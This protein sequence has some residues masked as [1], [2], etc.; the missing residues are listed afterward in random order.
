MTLNHEQEAAAAS[1][2]PRRVI[3][4]GPGSGKSR[5]LCGAVER[6]VAHGADPHRICV[7]TF[8]NESAR[9]LER[10]LMGETPPAESE[11]PMRRVF[12][13]GYCGTLHGLMLR[14]VKRKTGGNI[15][16]ADEEQAEAMLRGSMTRLRFNGTKSSVVEV[17][18]RGPDALGKTM[19]RAEVVA[20]DYWQE[21]AA[22][23]LVDY[24]SLLHRGLALVKSGEAGGEFTHLFVDETQ[25][26]GTIDALI[27]AAMP[28]ENKF[29]VGD[30]DQ[31]IYGFRGGK[32]EYLLSVARSPEWECHRLDG[33]YRCDERICSV[34]NA[35][36]AL[37]AG[38]IPKATVSK[39]L[40]PGIVRARVFDNQ[41]DEIAGA[42]MM[43]REVS[44]LGCPYENSAVLLRSNAL[45]D[46][47]AKGI[48]AMGVPVK[49]R[50]VVERPE[51]WQDAKRFLAMLA[52]PFNDWLV[53]EWLSRNKGA[54]EVRRVRRLA[55][56]RYCSVNEV[57]SNPW[58]HP[59]AVQQ[60]LAEMTMRGF[61]L[62]IIEV[63]EHALA[64]LPPDA[65]LLELC[66]ALNTDA[67]DEQ[68]AG[69]TVSTIHAAKG[70]EW[71]TVILPAFD[72]QVI[73][74]SRDVEEERRL[75]FVAFTRAKVQLVVT[76]AASRP[77]PF[78]KRTERA[79]P[80]NFIA[81]AGIQ[82]PSTAF[83]V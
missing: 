60:A 31:S 35:L 24:D 48:A 63:V 27:Y 34:A 51:G 56:E 32:P 61:S 22:A 76:T 16:V 4:A 30:Y 72:Q 11:N 7:V 9:E 29:L 38:R 66:F 43:L 58:P 47:F 75:A 59:C 70:R 20:H 10:R 42:A 21:M 37:N 40:H 74:A 2:H 44:E 71:G 14:Y 69:V 28:T 80:S 12:R 83:E 52:N 79:T 6:A 77:D 25:D 8:T 23:G 36:I 3:I 26:S 1:R 68:G 19:T 65:G 62:G 82:L 41:A 15:A 18:E 45:V 53:C 57:L 64:T 81:E 67:I 33:N 50:K 39:T 17:I 78:T 46:V 49:R 73:P 55:A 5:T 13:P 54:D